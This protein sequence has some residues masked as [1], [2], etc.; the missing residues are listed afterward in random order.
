MCEIKDREALQRAESGLSKNDEIVTQWFASK[1]ISAI[2]RVDVF[3]FNAWRAKGRQV[4]KGESGCKLAV[5]IGIKSGEESDGDEGEGVRHGKKLKTVSVFHISQTEPLGAPKDVERIPVIPRPVDED[6][7]E[8]SEDAP[9]SEGDQTPVPRQAPVKFVQNYERF[10]SACETQA[11]NAQK[12]LAK[13]RLMNTTRR[14]RIARGI[15][16][17]NERLLD[18]ANFWVWAIANAKA[19]L[20]QYKV[21]SLTVANPLLRSALGGKDGLGDLAAQ[22]KVFKQGGEMVE[23]KELK[24]AKA[25]QAAIGSG[26]DFFATNKKMAWTVASYVPLGYTEILDLCAGEGALSLA[27][28]DANAKAAITAVDLSEARLDV[29]KANFDGDKNIQFELADALEFMPDYQ[30]DGVVCNPPFSDDM[31]IIRRAWELLRTGGTL[32][33]IVGEGVFVNRSRAKQAEFIAW[34]DEIGAKIDQCPEG[35][36]IGTSANA[37]HIVAIK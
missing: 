10:K 5:Y 9:A 14:L 29:A 13:P 17:S 26:V 3:T 25:K 24:I 8:S 30:F 12:E 4:C 21:T 37:R 15:L 19:T 16:E 36:F 27:V 34:L 6:N 28:R 32:S 1:G 2:P 7:G 11:R 22:Y 35:S 33:A 20:E 23:S 31:A 18:S